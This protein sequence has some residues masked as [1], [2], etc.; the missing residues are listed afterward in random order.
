MGSIEWL[1][2]KLALFQLFMVLVLVFPTRL[3]FTRI[4]QILPRLGGEFIIC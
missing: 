1:F 3:R 2:L 4:R